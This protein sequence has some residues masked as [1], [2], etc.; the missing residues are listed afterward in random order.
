[1]TLKTSK[2]VNSNSESV[3]GWYNEDSQVFVPE[4]KTIDPLENVQAHQVSPA[5]NEFQLAVMDGLQNAYKVTANSLYGQIGAKT[6]HIYLKDIAACTTS[7][8]RKMIMMA[9][10]FLEEKY[11]GRIVYGDTDSVFVT[12]PHLEERGHAKINPS[13]EI[14]KA[15]SAEFK[16]LIKAPHDLEYEKTFWPFVLLS[17]KRY[18]GNV[19]EQ[20][21]KKFKQKSM[22][23]VLKRRDNAQI[24]KKIYGG[25]ID[26]I[27][28]KQDVPASVAFLKDELEDLIKGQL[29]LSDLVITK[30]LKG[31]YKDPTRI[32]HKVLADR[33]TERD[34]GNAPQSNDRIPYVYVQTPPAEKGTKMLQG[35][36]IETPTFIQENNLTPDYVFYITNQ[37]MKPIL[38][39]YALVLEQLPGY[40]QPKGALQ[41]IKQDILRDLNNDKDKAA[42]KFQTLKEMLVKE[43]LFDPIISRVNNAVIRQTMVSKKYCPI[44]VAT[45]ATGADVVTDA[46]AAVV[47]LTTKPKRIYK[48]KIPEAKDNATAKDNANATTTATTSDPVVVI[49]PKRKYT[50]KTIHITDTVS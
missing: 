14:A 30:S 46:D 13:I 2:I 41:R 1:M 36:K 15:A 32:A 33:I 38:Q 39:V 45:V 4:D 18:V 35:E 10:D 40:G 6:S 29:P 11:K 12:F 49:K 47:A 19:Y 26:I 25:I 28:S 7:T 44:T 8:G 24:V 31:D 16:K 5:F 27:L 34:P 3:V 20:D 17:K 50:R 9:K 48:K 42:D 37:I 21:D 43:I 22:G 23:I